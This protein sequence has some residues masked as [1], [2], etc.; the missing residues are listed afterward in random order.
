MYY[1]FLSIVGLLPAVVYA[2]QGGNAPSSSMFG[3]ILPMML[4]M[5]IIIYFLMIRPEQKKQ[6]KR[7]QMINEMKKGDKVLTVG[8]IYGRISSLK[9]D[10]LVVKI[11]ENTSVEVTKTAVSSVITKDGDSNSDTKDKK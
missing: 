1:L 9:G 4:I 6:K 2:Q 3:S 10:T 5:F 8:G 11:A 7:Q